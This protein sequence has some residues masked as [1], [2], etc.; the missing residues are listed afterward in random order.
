MSLDQ[1]SEY[2]EKLEVKHEMDRAMRSKS[3]KHKPTIGD[4]PM[5]N[6]RKRKGR[7]LSS[8]GNKITSDHAKECKHCGKWNPAPDDQCSKLTKHVDKCPKPNP[9]KPEKL[10]RASQMQEIVKAINKGK[11]KP[12]KCA[13][14][15][16]RSHKITVLVMNVFPSSAFK[17]L[18]YL[19]T[20]KP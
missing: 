4:E 8:T 3:D 10:F 14:F 15:P 19:D 6:K 2:L 12:A 1:Y 9:Y 20:K 11:D 7:N 17:V 18:V 16:I 5:T 13:K